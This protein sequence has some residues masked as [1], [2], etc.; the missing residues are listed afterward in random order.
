MNSGSP[1]K[2]IMV[3]GT[4]SHAGKSILA[5]ALCRIFARDG[6]QVAPFKAQNMSLN[7]FATPD[8]GEI[9]RSQAVQ[10]A[11]AMTAPRVEM[12]PLLLKPEGD[13]RS[14]VV[15]M[16]R[17]HAVKSARD[18][19]KMK[20][21]IWNTVTAALDRLRA[22]YDVIVI[23]GAG[24][25]AEV[26]L[27]Q[28][29]IVNMRVA[30]H[31]GAPVLLVGDIDRGGVF[32]Q[33]V[34]TMVLLEPEERALVKG[35]VINKFRGDSSLLTDGLDFLERHT[36]TPVAGVIPYFTDI[37]IAEEDSL[38]LV[39]EGGIAEE[40]AVDVAVIRLPHIANFD[41][42]DPLVHESCRPPTLCGEN[43]GVR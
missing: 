27:K 8:G 35:L 26:N 6:L 10:S 32:A 4:S 12:N 5:T 24:S 39:S 37:H 30:L 31:S 21:R 18:Y 41:D 33:L 9:G 38:G 3:Q 28:H 15:L 16:G 42:F 40:A 29:D 25:P 19:Y 13:N 36:G 20:P 7:S 34:G 17:P 43:T 1:A 11:A 22:E 2:I 23:E 14:Q